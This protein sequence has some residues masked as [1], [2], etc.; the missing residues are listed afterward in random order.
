MG[1]KTMVGIILFVGLIVVFSSIYGCVTISPIPDNN[2]V[3]AIDT[4]ISIAATVLDG[5][6]AVIQ[7]YCVAGQIS[8]SACT[9]ITNGYNLAKQG[10]ASVQKII[11]DTGSVD[12]TKYAKIVTDITTAILEMEIAI[13]AVKGG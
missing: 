3:A 4:E 2:T 11:A 5:A 12:A 9:N 13:K 10:I 1:I 6:Y 8:A 7:Q